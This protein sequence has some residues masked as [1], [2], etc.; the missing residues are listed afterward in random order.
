[1]SSVTKGICTGNFK[2]MVTFSLLIIYVNLTFMLF[3]FNNVFRLIT[4]FNIVGYV[5]R[6]FT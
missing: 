2:G 3:Y 5:K 1:M 4:L 6:V